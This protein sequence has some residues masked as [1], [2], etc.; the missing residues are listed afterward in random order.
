[1][2]NNLQAHHLLRSFI[3]SELLA[4]AEL[5]IG[6]RVTV[7]NAPLFLAAWASALANGDSDP[8]ID[9][10]AESE[11]ANSPPKPALPAGTIQ[12]DRA[13]CSGKPKPKR[14]EEWS[15]LARK[16]FHDRQVSR[17]EFDKAV[18]V[19]EAAAK[20]KSSPSE[21]YHHANP[22]R[23]NRPTPE[24]FIRYGQKLRVDSSKIDQ[25]KKLVGL[26]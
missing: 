5:S 1:M 6:E 8:V 2:L 19:H 13:K 20:L 25:L 11:V 26:P 23:T 15:D 21:L 24:A 14:W 17:E 22:T 4:Q 3:K 10:L 12:Y 18:P 9:A 7:D 16:S